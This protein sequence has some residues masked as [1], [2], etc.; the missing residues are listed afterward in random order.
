MLKAKLNCWLQ[1]ENCLDIA[2]KLQEMELVKVIHLSQFVSTKRPFFK[3]Q[4]FC[5]D[6][7]C[8]PQIS[9]KCGFLF[10]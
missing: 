9:I 4:I 8:P 2:L 6:S 3:M 7:F 5:T 10:N 1:E